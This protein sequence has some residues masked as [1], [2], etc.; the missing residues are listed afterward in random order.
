MHKC[1]RNRRYFGV[2]LRTAAQ[3]KFL[4][5]KNKILLVINSNVTVFNKSQVGP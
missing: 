2:S 1:L 3:L 5:N 4:K